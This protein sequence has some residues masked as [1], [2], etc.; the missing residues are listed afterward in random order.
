[1]KIGTQEKKYLKEV[2]K[3][4]RLES[5]TSDEYWSENFFYFKNDKELEEYIKDNW[6]K[7]RF[8]QRLL[9]F[10]N[11]AN[12]S[13]SSV[14]MEKSK[15]ICDIITKLCFSQNEGRS[16]FWKFKEI[17]FNIFV[18]NPEIISF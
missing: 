7:R 17:I 12:F 5:K 15:K 2:E 11:R 14:K 9:Q 3:Y 16:W 6:E 8:Q 13:N 4:S 18:T 10:L 1:M